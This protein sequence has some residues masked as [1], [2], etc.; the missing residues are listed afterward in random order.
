LFSC[1]FDFADV[2]HV[3]VAIRELFEENDF[4]LTVDD[5][6]LLSSNLVRVP[7]LVGK[8]QLVY[9]FASSV[10]VPYVTPN[11]RTPAK[12]E[13]AVTVHV[14]IHLDGTYYVIPSTI[15]INGISLTP[16]RKGLF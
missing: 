12:V 14:I 2:E 4:T 11:L 3:D 9:V 8:H 1:R 7:L 16:S 5:L 15:D 13:Q 10:P 6:T